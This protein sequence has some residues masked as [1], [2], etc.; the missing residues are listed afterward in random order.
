[1]IHMPLL[2]NGSKNYIMHMEY[3]FLKNCSNIWGSKVNILHI[4]CSCLEKIDRGLP[5]TL[6]PKLGEGALT[7]TIFF[8]F[9]LN[10]YEK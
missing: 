7:G 1:M 8:G 6:F 3:H 5:M 4:S 2:I 10:S 9:Y